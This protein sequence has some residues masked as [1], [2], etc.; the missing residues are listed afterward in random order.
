MDRVFVNLE[1]NIF[2]DHHGTLLGRRYDPDSHLNDY[3][4]MGPRTFDE[5]YDSEWHHF[6]P[7]MGVFCYGTSSPDC[8]IDSPAMGN[9][10]VPYVP[11]VEI[12]VNMVTEITYHHW[13][14]G[15][16]SWESLYGPIVP[17]PD[18]SKWFIKCN[19]TDD[20]IDKISDQM[21]LLEVQLA[22]DYVDLWGPPTWQDM[23]R[24]KMDLFN[25]NFKNWVNRGSASYY[26]TSTCPVDDT[27]PPL[28]EKVQKK[29]D[30]GR[31]LDCL[32]AS[33][34]PVTSQ[35]VAG[36][37]SEPIQAP[38]PFWVKT[39]EGSF[40]VPADFRDTAIRMYGADSIGEITKEIK[41]EILDYQSYVNASSDPYNDDPENNQ[42]YDDI[43]GETLEWCP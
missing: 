31:E 18:M 21:D 24:D 9:I 26:D 35:P 19:E 28:P 38:Q 14:D 39:P 3:V 32:W 20:V 27:I 11:P 30:T 2:M 29:L 34:T 15:L 36:P 23:Q 25:Y 1:N 10:P 43:S 41:M 16:P 37:S 6:H 5:R 40:V 17:A 13:T 4:F 8:P 7:E 12:T 42:F 22:P 33:M